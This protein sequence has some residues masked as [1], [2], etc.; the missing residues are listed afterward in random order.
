[1]EKNY[2]GAIKLFDKALKIQPDFWQA[3][4][5][6]GLAYFEKD[7]VNLS[8]KL[9]ENALLIEENAAPLLGLAS[10]IKVNDTKLA[11]QLGK[12]AL[13][14]DPKYVN[15][16]YRNEQLWGEK[17][18]ASTEILLQNEQLKKDVILAKS[19]ISESS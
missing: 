8:I 14:K 19:K 5:N 6:Q 3:I 16:D 10:C 17:L 7:N 4:N 18:Q 1:M 9:F 13:A 11:I 15:Y 2:I 12:K